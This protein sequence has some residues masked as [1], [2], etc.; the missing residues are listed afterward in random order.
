ME[1][2]SQLQS[3][4]LMKIAKIGYILLSVI[5]CALG[6]IRIAMPQFPVEK[7]SIL[8]GIVFVAFGCIR[9][10]GFY[11]KDLYRLAFQYDF[12]F[13]I[14]IVIL[15]ILTFIRSGSFTSMTCVVLGVLVLADALFKIRITLDAK[16]F[17]ID[18]WLLLL[19][20]AIAA[21]VLG[22]ILVFYFGRELE[23]VLGIT[24]IAEGILS[25]STALALVKII[26]HQI[27]EET[28]QTDSFKY[29][30]RM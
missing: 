24:L 11:S 19:I 27:K 14:L 1:D 16:K 7:F 26:R 22:G 12:E 4:I 15:G 6:I 30:K 5:L 20:I 21:A 8:C 28:I 25:F 17:G 13:G 10:I 2:A 29:E 18:N 3:T 9:L 23:I